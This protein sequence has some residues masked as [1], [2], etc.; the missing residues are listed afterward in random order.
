MQAQAP[1]LC[2]ENT[3]VAHPPR[4][5]HDLETANDIDLVLS[6]GTK[7]FFVIC[8]FICNAKTG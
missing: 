6:N 1:C 8:L 4:V 2:E 3:Q 5:L 7:E